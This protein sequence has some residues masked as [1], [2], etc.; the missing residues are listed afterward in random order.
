MTQS[1]KNQPKKESNINQPTKKNKAINSAISP[2]LILTALT[3]ITAIAIGIYN[4]N[5][6][7]TLS[8]NVNKQNIERRETAVKRLNNFEQNILKKQ[9]DLSQQI[10]IDLKLQQQKISQVNKDILDLTK[11]KRGDDQTWKLQ[12]A[13][14]LISMAQLT[15][16]WD[17]NTPPAISLLSSADKLISSLNNP[18]F[19]GIRQSLSNEITSLKTVEPIDIT[20]IL[21]K[22]NSISTQVD[23]LP[24]KQIT[25]NITPKNE[26]LTKPTSKWQQALD[27]S[28][29][30]FSKIIIIRRHNIDFKPLIS[31]QD[32]QLLISQLKLNIRQTQW[33]LIHQKKKVYQSN[34]KQIQ[35]TLKEYF[36]LNA[37]SNQI[38][39]Q[40]I[41][42]LDKIKISQTM[43]NINRS[44]EQLMEL[45]KLQNNQQSDG[46]QA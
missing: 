31:K 32:K 16:H 21:A 45:I 26:P 1:D 15:L 7:L 40:S 28:L 6:N 20:G 46:D 12:R 19:I 27:K 33:A 4:I 35:L 25:K 30:M 22:L 5:Q 24:L 3:S 13:A 36:D 43:P 44:Y 29:V 8:D 2:L 14:Y 42:E 41:V 23:N 37:S 10:N 39:L 9:N 18:Q 17:K 34:L 11:S 38:I